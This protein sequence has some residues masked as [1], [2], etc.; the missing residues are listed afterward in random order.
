MPVIQP[1]C[2]CV[3]FLTMIAFNSIGIHSKDFLHFIHMSKLTNHDR[4]CCCYHYVVSFAELQVNSE[5]SSYK[6]NI[7]VI[8]KCTNF[9]FGTKKLPPKF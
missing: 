1:F 6:V 3:I 7:K 9:Y 4:Y 5:F 2:L 8:E